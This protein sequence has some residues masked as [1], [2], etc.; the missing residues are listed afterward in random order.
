MHAR[1]DGEG[2]GSE[3]VV[4]L[5]L[6]AVSAEEQ[7]PSNATLAVPPP[8]TTVVV[9]E[10][11]ADSRDVLCAMLGGAGWTCYGAPPDGVSAD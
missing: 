11:Y 8:G 3:F 6:T 9:V 10:D 4:R 2:T 1:S 5:P 7:S